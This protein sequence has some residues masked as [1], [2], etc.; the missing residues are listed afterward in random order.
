MNDDHQLNPLADLGDYEL[1]NEGQ[2]IRGRTVLG[3]SGQSVGAVHDLLV[4]TKHDRVAAVRLDDG[5]VIPVESLE[6]RGDEVALRA[7]EPAGLPTGR[8]GGE[9]QRIPILQEEILIGRR[10]VDQ[11]GVRVQSRIVEEPV[12]EDVVLREERLTVARRPVTGGMQG[13][14]PVTFEEHT[15]AMTQH[16]EEP[17]VTKQA[18]VVEEVIVRKDVNERVERIDD[19][20]RHT[21]VDVQDDR[22]GGAGV[23]R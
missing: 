16:A 15:I 13:Q 14:K 7:S 2:D 8:P 22:T 4:D 1:K 11:G 17:V 23:D 21:E 20:V 6:R 18:R 19:T 5:S 3:L 10:N 9:E 12:H